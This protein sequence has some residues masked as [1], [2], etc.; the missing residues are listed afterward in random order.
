MITVSDSSF[1]IT[2]P[3]NTKQVV[4]E[5]KGFP[6]R[7]EAAMFVLDLYTGLVD[8]ELDDSSIFEPLRKALGDLLP[9]GITTTSPEEEIKE[10]LDEN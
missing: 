8:T 3:G 5:S 9:E 4:F 6:N 10:S 2:L 7:E 1:K